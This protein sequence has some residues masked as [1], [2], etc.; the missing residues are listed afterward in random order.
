MS[1]AVSYSGAGVDDGV[2]HVR[3]REVLGRH[4]TGLTSADH[5]NVD[6]GGKRRSH[7]RPSI[8][9]VPRTDGSELD[10][11]AEGTNFTGFTQT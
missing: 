4:E 11:R 1:P 9:D 8:A 3:A 10:D 2:V 6:R 7:V 5:Q